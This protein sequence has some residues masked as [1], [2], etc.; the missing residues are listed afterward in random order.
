MKSNFSCTYYISSAAY[1]ASLREGYDLVLLF[2]VFTSFYPPRALGRGSRSWGGARSGWV[3]VPTGRHRDTFP[4][5]HGRGNESVSSIQLQKAL[6]LGLERSELSFNWALDPEA[7][8]TSKIQKPLTPLWCPDLL[9]SS[10]LLYG[11]VNKGSYSV[12][13]PWYKPFAHCKSMYL[14]S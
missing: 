13:D 1:R 8:D 3:G 14:A 9:R 7:L 11:N 6:S 10:R 5:L 12:W 2:S 4:C